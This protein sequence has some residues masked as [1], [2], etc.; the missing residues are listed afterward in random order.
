MAEENQ[1]PFP[2]DSGYKFL[3]SSKRA[4]LQL[5]QSFVKTGWAQAVDEA[6]L[7]RVDKSFILPDFKNK[8]ADLVYQA[9]LKDQEVIFYLLL[10]LQSTVD[11]FIPYRLLLYMTEIW[12][13]VCKN[14][15]PRDMKRK[16]FRLPAIVPLVLYNGSREWTAPLSFRE[17]VAAHH[18]FA[19]QVP[20]FSYILINLQRY[21]EEE[22]LELSN[23]IGSVFFL[24]RGRDIREHLTNL[25]R[26]VVVLEKLP[27]EEFEL[28]FTWAR[29]ILLRKVPAEK[30]E[31]MVQTLKTARPEEVREVIS[32]FERNLEKAFA[33][34]EERGLKQGIAQ[35]IEQGIEK[36]IA[37][38]IEK[39]IEK[40]IA[41]G[42][43]KGIEQGIEKVARQMLAK[44]LDIDTVAECTGLARERIAR[45]KQ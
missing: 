21:R 1:P 18:L 15:P 5:L 32:N 22:L 40:G 30:R 35:G 10:E 38:G 41:Q 34:A 44:G 29:N 20:D 2:H 19:D 25:K 11:Y 6:S 33:E 23:L 14:T 13:D 36:G 16:G 43:E 26:L 45:L 39:G 31:E 27:P 24:D 28:F 4:F 37:Q 12:R 8:E 42:I 7:V 17:T 3:F 9:S